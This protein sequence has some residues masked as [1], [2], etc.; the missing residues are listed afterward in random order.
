MKDDIFLWFFIYL[1]KSYIVPGI[2][3]EN[4]S[5]HRRSNSP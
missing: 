1:Y 2:A 5:Y 3:T 4:R